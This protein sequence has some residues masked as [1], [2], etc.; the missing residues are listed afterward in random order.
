M[1]NEK[2]S[3][4][5]GNREGGRFMGRQPIDSLH[6]PTVH[7]DREINL[8][9]IYRTLRY[10]EKIRIQDIYDIK[11]GL[12]NKQFRERR[13]KRTEEFYNKIIELI[14]KDD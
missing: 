11:R 1:S 13:I 4:P 7:K 3:R 6:K 12:P 14:E 5:N 8:S 10:L 9:R 2:E